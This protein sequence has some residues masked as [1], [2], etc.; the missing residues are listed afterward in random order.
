[1][2]IKR[3]QRIEVVSESSASIFQD[4]LN[5]LYL[6]LEGVKFE[7]TLYNNQNGFTAYVVFEEI[8]QIAETLEDEYE[9]KGIKF[10]CADCPYFEEEGRFDGRCDFCRGRL[11]R[12]DKVCNAFWQYME[13]KEE[14]DMYNDLVDEIKKQ[15]PT[16]GAYCKASGIDNT[17]LSRML[18]GK[19]KI[20]EGKK[21]AILRSLNI[22][23]SE[24]NLA[25]YFGR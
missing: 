5:E 25:K 18:H 17:Y 20:T 16:F 14:G 24:E 7:Q 22:E 13:E 4:K 1:M 10:T 21:V 2:K 11:R 9:I 23:V 12:T 15:Y 3:Y 19:A 6:K 8:E